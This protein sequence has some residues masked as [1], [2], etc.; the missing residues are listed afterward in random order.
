MLSVS[1]LK[2]VNKM[3]KMLSYVNNRVLRIIGKCGIKIEAHY[4]SLFH[5]VCDIT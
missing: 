3:K 4:E 5:V 1:Y 2:S